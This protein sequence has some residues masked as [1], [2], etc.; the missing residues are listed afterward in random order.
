M[1][2]ALILTFSCSNDSD[3]DC[4]AEIQAIFD[5]YAPLIEAS[6]DEPEVLQT[7]IRNRDNDI[8]ALDC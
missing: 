2:S 5:E 8:A 6:A 7:L 3:R 1:I 4:G